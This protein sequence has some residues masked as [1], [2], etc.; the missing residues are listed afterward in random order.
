LIKISEAKFVSEALRKGFTCSCEDLVQ[1][2][3]FTQKNRLDLIEEIGEFLTEHE[4]EVEPPLIGSNAEW[5][6]ERTFRKKATDSDFE[7]Y[8]GNAIN[9]GEGH[10]V[11]FKQTF[12]LNVKRREQDPQAKIE[13]LAD[14]RMC[15][16]VVKTVCAF[17]N[18]DGGILL[19][20]VCD[21][22]D[23]FGIENDFPYVRRG[24]TRD[25]WELNLRD[26]LSD[27]IPEYRTIKHFVQI[28]FAGK[29]GSTVCVIRVYPRSEFITLCHP[30][31]NKEQELVYVREGNQSPLLKIKEIEALVTHKV[32][33]KHG[34]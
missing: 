1:L 21:T 29:Y 10:K 27:R 30:H 6:D 20:G 16:E 17:L 22:G 32:K 28:G 11:E 7:I 23:V 4:L 33:R 5:S 2:E 13:D 34:I 14:S 18:A 26:H 9:L 19:I 12:L 25:D 8:F 24:S 3:R 15:H 31:N